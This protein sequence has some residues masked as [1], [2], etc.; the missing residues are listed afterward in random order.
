[1][2]ITPD[3]VDR[4]LESFGKDRQWLADEIG[5][6]RGTLNNWFSARQFPLW[7][8]KSISRLIAEHERGRSVDDSV[9]H[10]S[11]SEWQRIQAATN[12]SGA[13]S[14]QEFVKEVLLAASERILREED[15]MSGESPP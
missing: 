6:S 15:R 2:D 12:A 8:Q 5:C 3:I 10:F 9:P 11:L 7:A 14:V 13:A 4:F 1:M